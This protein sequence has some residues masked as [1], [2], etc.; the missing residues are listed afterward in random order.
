MRLIATIKNLP[1]LF[2]IV[3]MTTLV[4]CIGGSSFL[5]YNISGYAWII[6]FIFAGYVLIAKR[7]KI[8][9][10]IKIWLPWIFS[11]TCYVMFADE[12]NAL[13]RSIMII[14]PIVV[15]VAASKYG[16]D[17]DQMGNVTALYKYIASALYG[18]V[19]IKT[20][21][22]MSAALPEFAGLAPEVMTGTLLCTFF[23]VQFAQGDNK[24]IA[25]WSALAAIPLIAVTRMGMIASGLTLVLTPAPMK[26][27]KRVTCVALI[28]AV[29]VPVFYSR[30][31][32]Q[33]MFYSGQGA[34]SEISFENPDFD[35]SGRK[36]MWE[37][38]RKGIADDPWFGHGANSSE[39]LIRAVT[40]GIVHPHNDYLR[41]FYDYGYIT[42]AI[43]G[44]CILLQFIDLLKKASC[45]PQYLK[46][47]FYAG[48]TSFISFL[49]FMFT[50]N[51]VLYAA[52]FGNLQF[53][54]LGLAYG[55]F[56]KSNGNSRRQ[57][58]NSRKRKVSIKW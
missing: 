31:V 8:H 23:A 7:G 28:I 11:V 21:I 50:D 53:T 52:F 6:S 18:I 57:H 10:P 26:F 54:I 36:H 51:I 20:G 49:M 33:K 9:F 3:V 43:F 4:A 47:L 32:Q 1:F 13:Q 41:L 48:A 29:T 46:V 37:V 27:V 22:L 14:C 44:I 34:I 24:A 16:L 56:E 38:M 45:S 30:R 19:I 40:G 5:G 39:A 25:W 58:L 2:N 35:T 42:S 15:G 17:V 55:S 12:S